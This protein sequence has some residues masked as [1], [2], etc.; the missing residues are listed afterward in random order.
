[1]KKALLILALLISLIA[2]S[3]YNV[4]RVYNNGANYFDTVLV[5]NGSDSLFRLFDGEYRFAGIIRVKAFINANEVGNLSSVLSAFQPTLVSGASIKTINN[6]SL[7]GSG[8]IDVA[9]GATTW[10]AITGTLS[11]QSDLQTALDGKLATN[12]N[13]SSLTSLTKG[14]VGLGNVDNTS[15]AN[16][17]VSS[18]TQTALN[19]KANLAS[20]TFTGTVSGVTAAMVGL[21][22]VNNTSDASKPISTATQTALDGKQATLVSATNIKTINGSTLLGSGDLVVG[23]GAITT[24]AGVGSSPTAS[25]TTTI[26]HNLGRVPNTVR[27]YGYGTFT[28]NAAATTTT[29]SMGVFNSSGNFC[30]YQ[31]YGAAITTT[32]AGLS[33]NTFAI[34]LATGGG[35]FISGVIQNVTST[36]FDIVWTETGTATAQVYLWE[37]Q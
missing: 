20:P 15:D 6:T 25:G 31:R 1:M 22:N 3:Q 21:G 2:S 23:G 12:G 13:G 7:L 29:S 35:S 9:A 10:G 27:I 28:S 30:V 26:T 36:Q 8:N 33:S 11:D 18:A 17:P 5:K 4:Y 19:L 37:A 14:Q 34:L 32:Q 24:T 16:K